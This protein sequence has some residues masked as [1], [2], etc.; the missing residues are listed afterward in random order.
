MQRLYDPNGLSGTTDEYMCRLTTDDGQTLYTCPITFDEVTPSR[1][2]STSSEAQIIGIYDT[3][4]RPV[5]GQ[6]N[7]GIYVIVTEQDGER[8][9][10]KLFI[11]E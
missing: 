5:S 9:S 10:N 3:M 7:K 4:G 8:T 2:Q 6:L 11:Y 1:T